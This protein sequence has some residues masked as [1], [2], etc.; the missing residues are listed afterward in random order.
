MLQQEEE[1]GLRGGV[2]KGEVL[3]HAWA[4]KAKASRAR[5]PNTGPPVE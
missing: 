1:V 5:R 3:H 2:G 4:L